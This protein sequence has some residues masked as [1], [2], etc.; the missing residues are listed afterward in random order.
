MTK[1]TARQRAK[2]YDAMVQAHYD[3]VVRIF[4]K[5][6]ADRANLGWG[7]SGDSYCS[8]IYVIP[9]RP[10]LGEDVGFVTTGYDPTSFEVLYHESEGAD[11]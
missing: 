4:G 9:D 1:L 3:E 10:D 11:D 7:D 8:K 2:A 6:R 5:E